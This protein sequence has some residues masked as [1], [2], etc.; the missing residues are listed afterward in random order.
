MS[1]LTRAWSAAR[2]LVCE[3]RERHSDP[4]MPAEW[5]FPGECPV[6][7]AGD[8]RC[9]ARGNNPAGEHRSKTALYRT[10]YGTISL[11][12]VQDAIGRRRVEVGA[13]VDLDPQYAVDTSRTFLPAI[14]LVIRAILAGQ[15]GRVVPTPKRARQVRR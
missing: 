7:C 13:A 14:D 6:W 3:L 12:A 10:G 8:H 11:I 4:S 5:R 1:G 2:T 15:P 9:T